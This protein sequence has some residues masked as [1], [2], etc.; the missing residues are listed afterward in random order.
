MRGKKEN[1]V[2]LNEALHREQEL[3]KRPT[4]TWHTFVSK[5]LRM[6][7]CIPRSKLYMN[8]IKCCDNVIY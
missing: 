2:K 4:Y 8:I 7:T 3:E 5:R 6:T 1:L